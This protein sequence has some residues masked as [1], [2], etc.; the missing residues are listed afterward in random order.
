MQGT[1]AD[2]LPIYAVE[3]SELYDRDGTPYGD[4]LGHDWHDND[5]RFA[6]L[7][8][9]A[10]RLAAGQ[11]DPNWRADV[12]HA[13]DWQTALIPAYL[14]WMGANVPSL[15]TIHNLAYQGLFSPETLQR[16]GAP[17]SAFQ[18]DGVEFYGKVSSSRP[19]STRPIT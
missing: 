8:S 15:L 9:A 7:A 16:I 11:L 12:V 19:G 3:C 1:S 14:S 13:N 5:V 17:E 4:I 2:G 6:V 18:I 10:A